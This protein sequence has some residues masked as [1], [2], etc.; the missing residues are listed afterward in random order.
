MLDVNTETISIADLKVYQPIKD[1]PLTVQREVFARVLEPI[2]TKRYQEK[3]GALDFPLSLLED[4]ILHPPIE[5]KVV[6]ENEVRYNTKLIAEFPKTHHLMKGKVTIAYNR[7]TLEEYFGEINIADMYYEDYLES[8]AED[9]TGMSFFMQ[10]IGDKFKQY[11]KRYGMY[12]SNYKSGY[13]R[14]TEGKDML[15]Q[16]PHPIHIKNV[17]E[18]SIWGDAA[19]AKVEVAINVFNSYVLLPEKRSIHVLIKRR[20]YDALADTIRET[21]RTHGENHL[22]PLPETHWR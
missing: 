20:G 12:S 11:F 13:V 8:L 2:L 1:S 19:F 3:F 7:A 10:N 6:M 15:I 16:F 18:K 5:E 9:S 17:I 14:L 21:E 4:V 22:D